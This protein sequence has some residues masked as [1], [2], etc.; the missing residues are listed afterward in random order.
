MPLWLAS[1]ASYIPSVSMD[2]GVSLPIPKSL[3][4]LPTP[5]RLTG[6]DSGQTLNLTPRTLIPMAFNSQPNIASS[7]ARFKSEEARYDF[8]YTSRDSLTPRFR[9]SNQFNES[10]NDV[11]A[12]RSRDHTVE[13]GVERLF[14]DTTE[15][16]FAAGY[17]TNETEDEI[18][19]HPF[20]SAD[21]RYPF[22]VSRRKLERT[23]EDI[24]RR[25]ELDDAQLAYIQT[26][27]S[28]LRNS[29]FRFYDVT[30]LA[31]RVKNQ[32]DR[33]LDLEKLREQ[34]IT[35]AGTKA[36]DDLV[37]LDAELATVTSNVRNTTGRYEIQSARFQA[38]I[39]I[40]FNIQVNMV[41]EPFNPFENCTHQE[42]L[43]TSIDTDPEIAT[44]NNSLKNAEVQ[45]DLAE[46]GR[47]DMAL[48]LG[49]QSALEGR[50][51]DESISDWSVSVGI[52]IS[53]VDARVTNSLIRQ[54]TGLINRFKQAIA[55]RENEIFTDTLEPLVRIETLGA[56]RDQLME[57][58]PRYLQDYETGVMNYFAGKLNIDD[59]LIRRKTLVEQQD[60]VSRL[61][62][63]VG[64]NVAE[65]CAATGKFFELLNVN[66]E[67]PPT[68]TPSTTTS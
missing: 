46:R 32:T 34:I 16:N 47:W 53:A 40:P 19:N 1:C 60:E 21:L 61:I 54:S 6:I 11:D 50:G 56:S 55:A 24:F 42:L 66:H 49:G 43:R 14:F 38:A 17:K 57:N 59:L 67:A 20:V 33:Q 51:E 35:Q 63:F 30:N 39:G 31:R 8:F 7:F 3:T 25:N 28:R 9:V 36:K 52:D 10:R 29:L 68:P 64:A 22:A 4:S 2:S 65:L 26:V 27:R 23:S 13:I 48:L 5:E 18:G 15:F 44:L 12:V 62:F 45:L 37:R 58:L 41:D